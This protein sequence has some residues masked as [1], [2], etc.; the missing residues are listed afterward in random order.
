MLSLFVLVSAAFSVLAGFPL[1]YLALRSARE[2]RELR[3]IQLELAGLVRE[4]KEVGEK[5]HWLQHEIRREQSSAKR[6]IDK[7]K[8]TVEQIAEAKVDGSSTERLVPRRG[9]SA[10]RTRRRAPEQL[11]WD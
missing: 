3:L 1:A 5:V 6:S 10:R 9:L 11:A 7:T 8:R 2:A 4:G